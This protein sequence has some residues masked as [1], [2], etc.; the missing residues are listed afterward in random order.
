MSET[1]I[2]LSDI[3]ALSSGK[4]PESTMDR[5]V[6][7]LDEADLQKLRAACGLVEGYRRR[8][9]PAIA[10]WLTNLASE[11]LDKD[12]TVKP[13]MVRRWVSKQ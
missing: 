7:E 11:Q 13:D 3:D 2:D 9:W 10:K 12:E 5:I 6:P 4:G 8:Q 1:D